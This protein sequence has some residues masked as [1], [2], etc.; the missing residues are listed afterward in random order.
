MAICESGGRHAE[1]LCQASPISLTDMTCIGLAAGWIFLRPR[2][3]HKP[4]VTTR[5][6]TG[7]CRGPS[8]NKHNRIRYLA[9]YC[10]LK[11]RLFGSG[12]NYRP[13]A[14]A[15]T[16]CAAPRPGSLHVGAAARTHPPASSWISTPQLVLSGNT[17]RRQPGSPRLSSP[18]KPRGIVFP[19]ITNFSSPQPA[20]SCQLPSATM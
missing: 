17:H 2:N 3:K 1:P 13:P 7:L 19:P 18:C 20:L 4:A 11:P 16:P 8:M 15:A 10:L 9:Q 14:R 5:S 12:H 6:T